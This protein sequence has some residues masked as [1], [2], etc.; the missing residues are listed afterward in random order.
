LLCEADGL[1]LGQDDLA[2]ADAR[3]VL[4]DRVEIGLSTHSLAQG[5][6]AVGVDLIAFGPVFATSSKLDTDPVV[7]TER[8]ARFCE[9]ASRPV[10]AIGGVNLERAPAI[11]A[12]G[13]SFGAAISA[14]CAADDPEA[15]ARAMHAA[16]GGAR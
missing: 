10:V 8:L 12:A 9:A 14:L 16:L 13:A 1:H 7:G 4:G 6:E 11:W 2:V 5:Q 3:T 15:T